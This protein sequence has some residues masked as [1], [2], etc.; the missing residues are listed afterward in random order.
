MELYRYQ[1]SMMQVQILPESW[2]RFEIDYRTGKTTGL[3]LLSLK[4]N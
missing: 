2:I 1:D 3:S 4:K